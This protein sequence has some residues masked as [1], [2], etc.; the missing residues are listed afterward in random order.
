MSKPVLV[1]EDDELQREMLMSL[2]RR[3]LEL[4]SLSASDGRKAL[5]ILAS[6]QGSSIK[7]LI[8]DM[9]MPVMSG[10]ETLDIVRQQY[11]HLPVVMLTGNK[12]IETAVAAMKRGATDYL[13]KPFEGE[14]LAITV[15]N[16]LKL[17]L[18]S[19]EVTRLRKE[20]DG[21]FGFENLI[22]FDGGLMKQVEMG[23]KAARSDIPV[24]LTGETGVGKEAF[25]KAIHGDS[26][27]AGKPFLA[28][29][30]GAIPQQL[31]ESTLFG[32]E[33][34][35][36][37]GATEKTLGKFR[38][39]DGG[40]ILLDEVGELPLDSQVKLLRVLQEKEVEP[41]GSARS[42]PVDV[43]IISATNRDLQKEVEEGRFREDL[44]FRLNVLEIEIPPLRSRRQDIV[45]LA[46]HFIE[47]FC[48]SMHGL[49]RTLA[50]SAEKLL[51][52]HGWSGNVREL[53]NIMQ[54][55]LVLHDDTDLKDIHF[56]LSPQSA[57][58]QAVL[59]ALSDGETYDLRDASGNFK[60]LDLIEQEVMA[61]ALSAADQNVTKAAEM[62]GVPK[63]TFYRKLKTLQ[64]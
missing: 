29:N 5:D 7:L 56:S 19:K 20:T 35:A 41:V 64:N 14:R 49:P 27:R 58:K 30:C 16:A 40:T 44:Y 18:L 15:R 25:A 24:L 61:L 3:K 55:T 38:E 32:H 12:D 2:L 22:G 8:M 57:S 53:E 52:Q 1:V 37:T 47:R 9:N 50:T 54:R 11:P 39:A 43:R 45:P 17:S 13:T 28:V 36:F 34:G 42:I 48:V 51:M 6:D 4:G 23:R 60:A 31:V 63:S 33:K 10:M 21:T 59:A 62:I 26:H 46:H